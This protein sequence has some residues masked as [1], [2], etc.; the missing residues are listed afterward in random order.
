MVG[1]AEGEIVDENAEGAADDYNKVLELAK[2]G[3]TDDKKFEQLCSMVDIDN[4][5]HYLAMQLFIDN[6][7]WLRQTAKRS[8]ASIRT[9]SGDISSTMQNLPGDF[10]R[11]DTQTRR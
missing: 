9:A 1:K 11:T 4:Y 6:R 8:Q 5:M 7:D 2:S 3:L 10:I